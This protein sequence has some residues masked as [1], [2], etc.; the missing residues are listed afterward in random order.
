MTK[1]DALDVLKEA[2]KRLD[3]IVEEIAETRS[4]GDLE[5]SDE[6]RAEAHEIAHRALQRTID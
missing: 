6:L 5:R 2:V 4:I 3:D 1:P